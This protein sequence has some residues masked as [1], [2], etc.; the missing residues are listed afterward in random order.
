MT[1]SFASNYDLKSIIAGVVGRGMVRVSRSMLAVSIAAIGSSLGDPM[2][3]TTFTKGISLLLLK[4]TPSI[5]S[6]G[7][8]S[9][10][11]ACFHSHK[12]FVAL[13]GPNAI[14]TLFEW[15]PLESLSSLDCSLSS[16]S[17]LLVFLLEIF[18]CPLEKIEHSLQ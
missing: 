6:L 5:A 4:S 16:S 13:L 3:G 2:V 18:N 11:C 1:T 15:I 17:L 7:W 14:N 10:L 9:S 8:V 12:T